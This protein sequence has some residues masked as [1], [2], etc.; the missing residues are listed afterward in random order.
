MHARLRYAAAP[1][2]SRSC[3]RQPRAGGNGCQNGI[4]QGGGEAEALTKQVE[5]G[6]VNGACYAGDQVVFRI[7]G[8]IIVTLVLR[9]FLNSTIL[10]YIV[11]FHCCY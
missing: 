4:F 9:H 7:N 11:S 3:K 6:W 2:I 5:K 1:G 10:I 8:A